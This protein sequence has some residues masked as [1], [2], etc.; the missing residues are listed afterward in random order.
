[1]KKTNLLFVLVWLLESSFS[2]SQFQGK[3][4]EDPLSKLLGNTGNTSINPSAPYVLDQIQGSSSYKPGLI[5]VEGAIDA[6]N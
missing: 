4:V 6:N 2:Y 1:M 3:D 5:P